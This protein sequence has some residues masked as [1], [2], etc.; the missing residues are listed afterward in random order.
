MY[1]IVRPDG[2]VRGAYSFDEGFIV[3]TFADGVIRGWWCEKPSLQPPADAGEVELRFVRDAR[4]LKIDGKWKYGS[5]TSATWHDD[6]D[7]FALAA[8]VDA[9]L[10]QRAQTHSGCPR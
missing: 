8:P 7:A 1:L 6:W 2:T 10:D 4:G 3:G 9:M 5:D